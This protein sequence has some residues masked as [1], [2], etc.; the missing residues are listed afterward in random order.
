M[1]RLLLGRLL[2]LVAG[3][4]DSLPFAA[5]LLSLQLRDPPLQLGN[6]PL[7]LRHAASQLR[8]PGD[9]L[10]AGAARLHC[11]HLG[12]S[13]QLPYTSTMAGRTQSKKAPA[14]PRSERLTI[15]QTGWTYVPRVRAAG[16][17]MWLPEKRFSAKIDVR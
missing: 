11:P 10:E 2:D 17:A 13:D 9:T 12:A 16:S 8:V 6:L 3:K 7:L 1:H 15:G 5:A 4:G 14:R